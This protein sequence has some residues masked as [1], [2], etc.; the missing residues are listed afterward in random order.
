MAIT[1]KKQGVWDTD[2]VYNKIDQGSIWTY[3][4]SGFTPTDSKT[5]FGWFGNWGASG[6]NKSNPGLYSSPVQL[7]TS[8]KWKD[9]G[10]GDQKGPV[11][12]IKTDGTLWC[13]GYNNLGGMGNNQNGGPASRSS[14]VQ[15]GTD[16]TWGSL[17]KTA[18]KISQEMIHAIKTDGTLWV[19]GCDA[20]PGNNNHQNMGIPGPSTGYGKSSP[21]QVG[22]ATNWAAI[23]N[24]GYPGFAW[25]V[26]TDGTLW[27][28]G[29]GSGGGQ[30]AASSGLNMPSGE[31]NIE[32]NG[33]GTQVGT[34]TTW[35]TQKK[36]LASTQ[37]CNAAIKTDGTLWLAGSN[38]YGL[39]LGAPGTNAHRSSPTQMGA[40]EDWD[41]VQFI[42]QEDCVALK[43]DGSL[44]TWGRNENGRLGHNNTTTTRSPK[45]V[46]GNWLSASCGGGGVAAV[47][48]GG[49]IYLWGSNNDG[50]L[51][52][53]GGANAYSSPIQLG[54][55]KWLSDI[56]PHCKYGSFGEVSFGISNAPG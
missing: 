51:G 30:P 36:H 45:Q 37:L 7:G 21:T 46:A 50:K 3:D 56:S 16:T 52:F 47:K 15:I 2:E 32:P 55:Y 39:V 20:R 40:G 18:G 41:V 14:P 19:W 48:D 44:W 5:L 22:T 6:T 17:Q 28:W 34:D 9:I 23:S 11:A 33:S 12:A 26:K 42:S 13:W 53:P 54:S 1:D 35:S 24:C 29:K 31:D 25:A 4:A 49:D 10:I 27:T 43:T 8:E 38:E